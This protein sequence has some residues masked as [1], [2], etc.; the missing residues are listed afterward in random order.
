MRFLDHVP[1]AELH[2]VFGMAD[3]FTMICRVRLGGLEQ[4][5]FGIVFVE[6]AACGVPQIAGLSGGSA[7]AVIDGET[8]FVVDDPR[9]ARAVADALARVFDDPELRAAMGTASR[10]RVER[11]FSY[12]LLANRFREAV[13]STI[14]DLDDTRGVA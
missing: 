7:E 8:G 9:D 13:V 3:V 14:A 10:E 12:D 4:E 11:E 1:D 2:R 5:G 6:A